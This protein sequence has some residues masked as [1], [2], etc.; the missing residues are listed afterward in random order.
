MKDATGMGSK[1]FWVI[2]LVAGMVAATAACACPPPGPLPDPIISCRSLGGPIT[3]DPPAGN[4]GVDVTITIGA[5]AGLANCTDN[6]SNLIESASLGGTFV[7]P[8]FTCGVSP[9]GTEIGAGSGSIRWSNGAVSAYDA[10][11]RSP[12]S[13][14]QFILEL[15]ITSGLWKGATATVGLGVVSSVGNCVQVPVTSA[16]LA[17]QGPFILHPAA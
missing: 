10:T 13:P 3:Y 1:R 17:S 2:A 16:V 7:L 8:A 9:D 4:A 11:L 5:G 12:G 6:T 15:R 14:N